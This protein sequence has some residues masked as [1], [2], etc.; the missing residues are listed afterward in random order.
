LPAQFADFAVP[1]EEVDDRSQIGK[2]LSV[3]VDLPVNPEY[4]CRNPE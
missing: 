1:L 2:L 3:S 4:S